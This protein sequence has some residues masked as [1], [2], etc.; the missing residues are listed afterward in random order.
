ML[1]YAFNHSLQRDD[2]DTAFAQAYLGKVRDCMKA[3]PDRYDKFLQ[4]MFDFGNGEQSPVKVKSD[5]ARWMHYI[6]RG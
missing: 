5:Q 3:D 4:Q 6:A 1:I 2:R